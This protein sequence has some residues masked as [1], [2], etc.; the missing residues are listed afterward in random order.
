MKNLKKVI[1]LVAVFAMMVSTVA[2]AQTFNDVKST[3]N[4]YEAIETLSKL[5]IITGD[6]QNNDG[7]MDFRPNDTITRAE[8]AV[9][10]S[11][12]QG[13]N[14][15]APQKTTF[16]D[17]AADYWAAG[18]IASAAS[19]GIVNGMGDGTFE[20][21]TNVKYEEVIKMLM[22]T[23]G[24]E[25]FAAQNGGYPTGYITAAQRHGVIDGVVG[26]GV[27][28]DAPRGMVA[29]M[30]Y[31]AI[32]TPLMDRYTYGS[33]DAEYII[34]DGTN[35]NS[36]ITLMS[37]DL[38]VSKLRGQVTDNNITSLTQPLSVDTSLDSTVKAYILD[39][40]DNTTGDYDELETYTFKAGESG[41]EKFLGYNVVF[42]VQEDKN[43]DDA[44]II[45][46]TEATGKNTAASFTL[47]QYDG[48]DKTANN[49]YLKY[50]KNESDRTATKLNI[51]TGAKVIYNNVAG[52]DFATIFEGSKPYVATNSKLGGQVRLLDTNNESGYDVIFVEIAAT[53]VVE[54]LSSRGKL[55]FK[56]SPGHRDYSN[57]VHDVVFNSDETDTIVT[58]TKD[59]KAFNY[60]DLKAWDVVSIIHNTDLLNVF[61]IKVLGDTAVVGSITEVSKSE[62]SASDKAYKIDGKKYDVAEGW[63]P[64]SNLKAG[65]AGTFYVDAYGKIVAYNKNKISEGTTS[66]SDKYA[67]VM[68]SYSDDGNWGTP[69]AQLLLLNKDG[70]TGTYNFA[71]PMTIEN[72]F[73]NATIKALLNIQAEEDNATFKVATAPGTQA[74]QV[75][76]AMVGQLITADI[77]ANGE[78]RKITL[79][80]TD[81]NAINADSTLCMETAGVVT[82][83]YD[84]TDK[85]F[86]KISLN[87]DT[88]VFFMKGSGD[89]TLGDPADKDSSSV[90]TLAQLATDEYQYVAY[91]VDDNDMAG[92]V[93]VYNKDVGI[94]PSANIAYIVSVGTAE[95]DGD[96]VYGVSYYM[97]GE[98]C[99]SYT[100]PDLVAKDGVTLDD[101]IVP[102]SVF[103]FGFKN[104][105]ISNIKPYLTF[106]GKVR[107]K[108]TKMADDGTP[109]VKMFN[110]EV[111]DRT[112]KEETYFGP[113][114]ERKSNQSIVIAEMDDLLGLPDL[115]VDANLTSVKLS[116]D[117]KFYLYDPIRKD[118]AKFD[119]ASAGDINTVSKDLV[120]GSAVNSDKP[121]NNIYS[122]D[123][124][125]GGILLDE[126]PAVGMLDWVFVREYD[127]DTSDVVIYLSYDYGSYYSV[128]K[129]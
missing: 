96:T 2:F 6:D 3:D 84:E 61:D 50:M 59:G 57:L 128:V 123:P 76:K 69:E 114:L 48:I 86:G 87:E 109:N 35:G 81:R 115:T 63:Y 113:V 53:G 23:L 101:K 77:N 9:I 97:N 95:V 126:S 121:V 103:K 82:A 13:M 27:G 118:D 40:Y 16:T 90:G 116:K 106:D 67:Y 75:A 58:I 74:A 25:P 12:I 1:A 92:A 33:G 28:T 73:Y 42:Y 29:Q 5:G 111:A 47:A 98:L 112:N 30:T 71:S 11:R 41:A 102:G 43:K 79:P 31:N 21:E 124:Q 88:F 17:V 78:I 24:Y 65:D 32:D 91:N 10:V 51:E 83:E 49:T 129:D 64:G 26:G 14:S 70:S 36:L 18:Y 127:G 37:R 62:T 38:K 46:M 94:S 34:Y 120:A 89:I 107:D 39:N 125:K 22:V 45:S 7:V 44:T 55:S 72:G 85:D 80:V 100:D 20:P 66:A 56:N 8:V 119:T 52:K 110:K 108:I 117:A 19:L 122:T 68:N 99:Y 4:Y 104:E 93:V 15:L 60:E 54:E 105:K